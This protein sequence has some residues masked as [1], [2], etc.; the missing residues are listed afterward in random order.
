[1]LQWLY[2]YVASVCSKCFICFSDIC[3][4]Y[5]YLDVAYVSHICCKVFYLDIA[6]AFAMTFK[7]FQVFLQA[8]QT[9][10]SSISSAFR[11]ML[12]IFHLLFQK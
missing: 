4:K 8:F 12:Q 6:H 7:C 5:V 11:H 10:V 9:Y 3:C 1:M 2:T